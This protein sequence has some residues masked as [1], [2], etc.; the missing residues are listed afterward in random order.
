MILFFKKIPQSF[1]VCD[2]S[3]T[4]ES[5]IPQDTDFNLFV[6]NSMGRT[7]SFLVRF[8]IHS[9]N[10]IVLDS[11]SNIEVKSQIVT[12][13][14]TVK[15]IPGRHSQDFDLNFEIFFETSELPALS[16]AKFT[17]HK[18]QVDEVDFDFDVVIE[19]NSGN[20]IIIDLEQ[21]KAQLARKL[22]I[23]M[24]KKLVKCINFTE[25]LFGY[26]FHFLKAK[27]Y[28]LKQVSRSFF[29]SRAFE[30]FLAYIVRMT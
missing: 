22:N 6:Y 4:E 8:P 15:A 24:P 16:Q 1:S 23:V 5:E 12:I 21:V 9:D 30:K 29:W 2:I 19:R 7:A 3:G 25:F 10:W 27:S 18:K 14:E 28:F 11:N 20:D 17:L 13:P 26:N